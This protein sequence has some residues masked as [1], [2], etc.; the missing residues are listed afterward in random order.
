MAFTAFSRALIPSA[1]G[2]LF[3]TFIC[4]QAHAG[5]FLYFFIPVWLFWLPYSAY[6]IAR[7][8]EARKLQTIRVGLW[9]SAALLI[10]CVHVFRH[11]SARH[12]ADEVV[13]KVQSYSATH[14]HYPP[15]LTEIGLSKEELRTKLRMGFY[16]RDEAGKPFFIYAATFE[17][18]STFS[19]D[20]GKQLWV[21]QPD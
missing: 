10:A 11:N 3:L 7:K 13:S 16:H 8:P 12:T 18:F 4:L 5:F 6:V 2:A 15:S 1:A 20:F 9:L 21:Y 14:G 17:P 19:Y